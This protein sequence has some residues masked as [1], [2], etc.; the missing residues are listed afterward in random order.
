MNLVRPD[1]VPPGEISGPS[2]GIMTLL[3]SWGEAGFVLPAP[4]HGILPICP[5]L[6]EAIHWG[7]FGGAEG[8]RTLDLMNAIYLLR[9]SSLCIVFVVDRHSLINQDMRG[10]HFTWCC[11]LLFETI[12]LTYCAAGI[13]IVRAKMVVLPV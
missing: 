7:F 11:P 12:N 1:S 13:S 8:D 2:W 4:I 6:K 9:I 10:N 5:W 3:S